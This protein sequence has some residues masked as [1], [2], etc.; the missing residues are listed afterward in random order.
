MTQTVVFHDV[1]LFWSDKLTKHDHKKVNENHH[2]R[3]L[4]KEVSHYPKVYHSYRIDT[5]KFLDWY[6]FFSSFISSEIFIVIY[7]I[8]S[9]IISTLTSMTY[10]I[11]NV[12]DNFSWS[13][14]FKYKTRLSLQFRKFSLKCEG[15]FIPSWL[16]R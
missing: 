12:K 11:R 9:C 14:S 8:N 7:F 3:D 1:P 16:L 10:L 2:R 4:V 5:L 6:P 13:I 15:N